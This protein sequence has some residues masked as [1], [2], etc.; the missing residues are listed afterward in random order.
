MAN[1]TEQSTPKGVL[2][3]SIKETG[4]HRFFTGVKCEMFG[5][6]RVY[7]SKEA[8][9]EG[10]GPKQIY[11]NLENLAGTV[12]HALSGFGGYKLV[13]MVSAK[14]KNAEQEA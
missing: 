7:D 4:A 12:L 13:K 8:Y 3:S 11:F 1:S 10:F 6:K 14:M 9:K 2:D 5:Q